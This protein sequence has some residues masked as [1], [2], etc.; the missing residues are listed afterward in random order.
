MPCTQIE[1]FQTLVQIALA[2]GNGLGSAWGQVL[3]CLSEFQRLHMIGTGAKTDAQLFFPSSDGPLP[4]APVVPPSKSKAIASSTRTAHAAIIQPTRP[5]LSTSA[6]GRE[7]R[8]SAAQLHRASPL[9][10]S[11]PL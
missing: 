11:T 6:G 8:I 10:T 1:A 3:K 7:V 2:D 5:R 4:T 9:C